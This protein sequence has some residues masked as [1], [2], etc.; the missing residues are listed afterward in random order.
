MALTT[1]T[2]SPDQIGATGNR[3]GCD[4]GLRRRPRREKH[5]LPAAHKKAQAVRKT[6]FMLA[7]GLFGW[8]YGLQKRPE[9]LDIGI[10]HARKGWVG[11]GREVV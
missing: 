4:R 8:W 6:Q 9:V 7:I 2:Q 5:Q 3:T 1:M 10:R 11:K